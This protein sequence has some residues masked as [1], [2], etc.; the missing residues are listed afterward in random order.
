MDRLSLRDGDP[1]RS[2]LAPGEITPLMAAVTTPG[3]PSVKSRHAVT[4]VIPSLHAH[5]R[6]AGARPQPQGHRGTGEL[7]SALQHC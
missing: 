4:A 7:S 5:S 2:F 1:H 3:K 6:D